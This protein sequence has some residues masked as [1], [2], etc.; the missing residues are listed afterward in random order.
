MEAASY[1]REPVSPRLGTTPRQLQTQ[2][3][4][5]LG[6]I[7]IRWLLMTIPDLG[8]QA[9]QRACTSRILKTLMNEDSTVP[10]RVANS[11]I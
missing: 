6:P 4:L 5:F 8:S 2:R 1:T 11:A 3:I 9:L 10:I 7:L